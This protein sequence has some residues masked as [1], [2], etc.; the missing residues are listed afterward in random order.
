MEIRE[1][2]WTEWDADPPRGWQEATGQRH[3]VCGTQVRHI[4]VGV[5]WSWLP[6]GRYYVP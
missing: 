4:V 3:G 1:E 5:S 2:Y 6:G